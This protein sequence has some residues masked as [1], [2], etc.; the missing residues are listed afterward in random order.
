MKIIKKRKQIIIVLIIVSL[1]IGVFVSSNATTSLF[2]QLG[3][4][5]KENADQDVEK[6]VLAEIN[7]GEITEESINTLVD[8]YKL[9]GNDKTKEEVFEFVVTNQLLIELAKNSGIEVSEKDVKDQLALT[10]EIINEDPKELKNMKDYI[11]SIG[12]TEDEYFEVIKSEYMDYMI[13]DIFKNT[14]ILKKFQDENPDLSEFEVNNRFNEYY[15]EFSENIFE[16][17]GLKLK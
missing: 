5:Y 15:K 1:V 16:N 7:G 17:S 14:Y 2:S 8:T 13:L 10:R 9:F 4:M 3:K 11:D 12:M 6:N